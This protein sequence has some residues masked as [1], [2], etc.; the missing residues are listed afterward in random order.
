MVRANIRSWRSE[1][2]GVQFELMRHFLSEQ[3][4]TE[5]ASS[6]Q[7]QRLV[8]TVL[9]V[10]GCVGPLI[11]RLYIEKYDHLKS[12]DAGDQYLAAVHADRLFFTALSMTVAGLATIVQWQGLFPNRRDYLALKPLPLRLYQVFAA[13]FLSA[14]VIVLVVVTDLNLAASVLFPFLTSGRWQA[15]SF[16]LRYMLAHFAVM[17][18]AGLF[19]F[20][21]IGALQGLLM[22]L[23]PASVFERLSVLIQVLLATAFVA[24][25]PY[26]LDMPNWNESIAAKPHWMLLFPPA[27][28]MGLYDA[29]L[30]TG[31][32]YFMQLSELAVKGTAGALFLALTM[33][34]LSYR[35]HASRV[36]EQ[37]SLRTTGRSPTAAVATALLEKFVKHPPGQATLVFAIQT[38]RRSRPHKLVLAFCAAISLLLAVNSAGP[39]VMAHL[40]S[41]ASGNVWQLQ[42]VLAAPLVVSAILVSGLCYVFQLPSQAAANWVFRMAESS[43]RLELLECVEYLLIWFGLALVLLVTLPVEVLGL[44]WRVALAHTVLVAVLMLLLTEVRLYEWHKIPF[45]CPYVPGRRNFWQTIGNYLFLFVAVIPTI[46]YFEARLHRPLLLLAMAGVLSLLYVSARSS[47]R[48]RWRT[49]PLQFDESDELMIGALRLNRE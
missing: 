42:S 8:V 11:V 26:V 31:D 2:H 19:M 16:G 44:G 22:N 18:T 4:V 45:T 3:V 10:I 37:A 41:G 30:G 17:V 9:A 15:P 5:L 36:L 32:S 13:R 46:T 35:R 34:L 14:F 28:F 6:D 38:L 47:R 21:A 43:G 40:R 1:T 39:S 48:A 49:V 24:A 23:L 25:V 12:L 29:L 33:Y 7:V 20:F 27:W